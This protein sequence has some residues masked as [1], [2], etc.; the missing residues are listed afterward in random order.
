MDVLRPMPWTARPYPMTGRWLVE[1][2]IAFLVK[3]DSHPVVPT[4]HTTWRLKRLNLS[5]SLAAESARAK[6]DVGRL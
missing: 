3:D 6:I 4:R 5:H 1:G 2:G